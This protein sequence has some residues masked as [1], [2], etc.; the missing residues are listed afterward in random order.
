MARDASFFHLSHTSQKMN[1]V[2]FIA[3][4]LAPFRTAKQDIRRGAGLSFQEKQ[5]RLIVQR[6][7]V[8]LVRSC[9]TSSGA[10]IEYITFLAPSNM[11][12]LKE[13]TSAR[14]CLSPSPEEEEQRGVALS[15]ESCVKCASLSD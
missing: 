15:R 11:N 1:A 4:S 2:N 8:A 6:P 7:R 10:V 13:E 3:Q 14:T 12:T 9:R 5:S